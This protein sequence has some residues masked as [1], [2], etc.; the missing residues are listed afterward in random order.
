MARNGH[1]ANAIAH[2]KYSAWA[3]AY[4][5]LLAIAFARWPIFKIVLFLGYLVVFR[6]VFCTEHL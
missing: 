1:N 6:A 4:H 2:A 5:R 3:L